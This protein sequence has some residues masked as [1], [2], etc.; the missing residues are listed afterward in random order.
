MTLR[1]HTYRLVALTLALLM[2]FTSVGF[3]MDMHYCQGK[4]KSFSLLGKAKNCHEKA[5]KMANC[6][7][8]QKMTADTKQE[9]GC[10]M[11]QKDCCQN[12][13]LHVQADQDL[14]KPAID[15]LH[16]HQLQQFVVAYV[17]TFFSNQIISTD[18]IAFARYKPPLI[19]RDIPVLFESFL[20]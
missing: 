8:H 5:A 3:T 12:R 4:L 14:Q 17:L 15:F 13:M 10:S 19:P 11:D 1:Y 20:I 18:T 9:N 7:H 16:N 2:F 6:P